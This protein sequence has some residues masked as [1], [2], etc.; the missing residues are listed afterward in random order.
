MTQ[1]FSDPQVLAAERG[2]DPMTCRP[3][4]HRTDRNTWE[5]KAHTWMNDHPGAMA[6]F[7]ELAGRAV[8]RGRRFGI[9]LLTERIRWEFRFE[10]HDGEQFKLNNNYRAYI[11]RELIRRHPTWEPFIEFREVAD[12]RA[13]KGAQ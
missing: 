1:E 2:D 9:G 5:A 12:E 8:A 13:M 6:V 10:R 3:H 4:D 7:E 11:A